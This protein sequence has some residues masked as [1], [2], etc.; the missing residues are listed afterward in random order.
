MVVD[1][2]PAE[3][4]DEEGKKKQWTDFVP[5]STPEA[6]KKTAAFGCGTIMLIVAIVGLIVMVLAVV[7]YFSAEAI[8]SG[9]SSRA[10]IYCERQ[11]C[12]D[13]YIK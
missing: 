9:D 8:F 5:I 13:A 4:K 10:N 7:G 3:V 2:K 6:R 12:R 11:Y 1:L